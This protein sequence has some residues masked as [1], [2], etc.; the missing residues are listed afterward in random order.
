MNAHLDHVIDEA[1]ALIPQERSAVLLALLD[2]LE[3]SDESAVSNAWAAEI[4]QRKADLRSGVANAVPWAQ[5]RA[6]LTTL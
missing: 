6:R 4:A 2:S 3:G 5:A 1:L